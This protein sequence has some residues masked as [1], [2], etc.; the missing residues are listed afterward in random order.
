M[1]EKD[2]FQIQ[3][4]KAKLLTVI[5]L[6][7][8]G[9][10]FTM[11]LLILIPGIVYQ[12]A[13]LD[14]YSLSIIPFTVTFLFS[15]A[16]LIFGILSAKAAEEEEE[17]TL[18]AKKK[19]KQSAFNTAEDVRF[20]AGRTLSNYKK[21]APYVFAALGVIITFV[22]LALFWKFWQTRVQI[23]RAHV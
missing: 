14:I 10:S 22:I 2:K 11:S 23:G 21:Y 9:G 6:F 17:K 12:W 5:S 13:G 3:I 18:L 19:E 7:A 15:I 1:T 4:E 8:A 16:S 20:T